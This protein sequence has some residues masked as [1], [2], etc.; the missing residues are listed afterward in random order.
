VSDVRS[1][2]GW[3]RRATPHKQQCAR[4]GAGAEP[5]LH[6]DPCGEGGCQ[7]PERDRGGDTS[8]G[9][10]EPQS[11]DPLPM[12]PVR[13][14]PPGPVSAGRLD[15]GLPPSLWTRG[16]GGP[17]VVC[18]GRLVARR[19]GLVVVDRRLGLLRTAAKAVLKKTPRARS[20][21]RSAGWCRCA[22]S[23]PRV[24]R[25]GRRADCPRSNPP[26]ASGPKSFPA[27]LRLCRREKGTCANGMSRST[28]RVY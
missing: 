10:G 15:L 8:Q 1:R 22:R 13:Q 11:A 4:T 2:V 19:R 7:S 6:G 28:Y 5:T 14:R 16:P 21:H 20:R 3:V 18:S 25:F 26:S 23:W 9:V 27:K 17:C 12:P 24:R